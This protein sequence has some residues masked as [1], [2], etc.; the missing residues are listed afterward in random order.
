MNLF[1]NGYYVLFL[2]HEMRHSTLKWTITGLRLIITSAHIL[3]VSLY[4]ANAHLETIA[5][6]KVT[7]TATL[8][9]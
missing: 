9:Q 3:H 6:F 2:I 8:E 5:V 7:R 4:I 1:A